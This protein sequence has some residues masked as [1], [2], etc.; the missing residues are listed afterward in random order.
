MRSVLQD[1]N[2]ARAR[3][4]VAFGRVERFNPAVIAQRYLDLYR[5]ILAEPCTAVRRANA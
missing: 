4:E 2:S 1:E 5:T 3:A